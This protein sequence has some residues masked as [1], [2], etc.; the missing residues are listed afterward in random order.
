M[1]G[2]P[3]GGRVG[4]GGAYLKWH[5]RA[6]SKRGEVATANSSTIFGLEVATASDSDANLNLNGRNDDTAASAAAV[7]VTSAATVP[8]MPV[9]LGRLGGTGTSTGSLSATD[10][11]SATLRP[12]SGPASLSGT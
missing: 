5:L 9:T 2:A 6:E 1:S 4:G 7:R 12:A 3:M 10:C 11:Q 8:I